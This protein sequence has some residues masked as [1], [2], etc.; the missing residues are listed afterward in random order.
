MGKVSETFIGAHIKGI[1]GNKMVLSWR[2]GRAILRQG[3]QEHVVPVINPNFFGRAIARISMDAVPYERK[4]LLNEIRIFAPDVVFVEY[5]ITAAVNLE[6]IKAIACPILIHFHG[7]DAHRKDYIE[8]YS[9]Q[10][11]ELSNVASG[12]VAV[13]EVM[14]ARLMH[15]GFC[16]S[17]IVTIPCGVD[18]RE[19]DFF[20]T[21]K[22]PPQLLFVGRFVDKKSPLCVLALFDA[23]RDYVPEA[24][25]VMVGDGPMREACRQIIELKGLEASV[26]LPGEMQSSEIVRLM[27]RSALYLQPSQVPVLRESAGDSEGTPVAILEACASGLPVVSTDHGGIPQ[28]I[29]DGKSGLLID[30]HDLDSSVKRMVE[31]LRSVEKRKK[32]AELARS[33]VEANYAQKSQLRKLN[34]VLSELAEAK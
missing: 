4:Y 14:K 28:V 8:K 9:D 22:N 33:R 29:E 25:L 20:D 7:F 31:L 6:L 15:L 17:K 26:E 34:K 2:S 12:F 19:F 21:S 24:N 18:V 27:R 1:D 3:D 11:H 10:Y 13:S 23:L 5:G 16:G 32:F 30:L